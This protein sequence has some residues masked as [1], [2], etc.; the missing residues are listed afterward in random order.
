MRYR[1]TADEGRPDTAWDPAPILGDMTIQ[2][3][4]NVG[5]VVEDL[6]STVAFSTALGM[7]Q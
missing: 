4:D 3:M 6:D 5:I 2:R 7:E 1:T